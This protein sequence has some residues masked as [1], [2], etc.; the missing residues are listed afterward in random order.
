MPAAGA[1]SVKSNED[2]K[3]VAAQVADELR[4]VY[5]LAYYPKPELRRQ[6]AADHRPGSNGP[7]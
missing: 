6:V 2:L 7:E 4:S 1:C 5:T 3:P